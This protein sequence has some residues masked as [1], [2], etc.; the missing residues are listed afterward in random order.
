MSMD[1]INFCDNEEFK[2]YSEIV[3]IKMEQRNNIYTY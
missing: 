2:D 3:N 1:E